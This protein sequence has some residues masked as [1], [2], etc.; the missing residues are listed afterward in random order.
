MSI[1]KQWMRFALVV[2]MLAIVINT[3][4]LI[5]LV[6]NNFSS[7]LVSQYETHVKQV[8]SYTQRA[9]VDG[10]SISSIR[11]EL[12]THI[13]DPITGIR[14]YDAQGH[15]LIGIA[16]RD[17][18]HE[19]MRPSSSNTFTET[20][21]L[22]W[23]NQRIGTI[24]ITA[25]KAVQE[26]LAAKDFTRSLLGYSTLSLLFV[27]GVAIVAAS[28]MSRKTLRDLTRTSAYATA[29]KNGTNPVLTTSKFAEIATIQTTLKQLQDQL[30][31]KQRTRKQLLDELVHQT[32]T[33]LTIMKAHLEGIQDGYIEWDANE[34]SIFVNQVD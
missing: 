30:R 5:Y 8:V 13:N 34:V 15:L 31:F 33:P 4:V 22:V 6:N 21:E 17:E 2:S 11:A 20:K 29:L 27:L 19:M 25:V 1:R 9:L 7:Y 26:F 16:Q 3:G 12:I 32:R 24:K 28:L 23:N 14:V 18:M 10:S